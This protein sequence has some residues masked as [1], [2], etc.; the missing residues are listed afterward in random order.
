MTQDLSSLVAPGPTRTQ[1]TA[2]FWEA[3]RKGR[4]I[5]QE[6]D[7]CGKSVFYPRAICPHCWSDKLHWRDAS[8]RGR[9]KSYSVVHRPGHP[10]WG[11]VVPYAIGL[12]ELEEGPTMLSQI[13]AP[14]ETIAVGMPL[15]VQMT[16]V[17]KET[18]PFFAPVQS[19]KQ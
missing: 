9:L 6:C 17:G 5:L 7:A 4:L 10:A 11:A 12:V 1:L 19:Q 18:L 8:G 2:P 15:M 16:Q 3:A 14:I 13:L